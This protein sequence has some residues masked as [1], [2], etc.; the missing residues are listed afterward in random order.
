MVESGNAREQLL[1]VARKL[2]SETVTA[3]SQEPT[4]HDGWSVLAAGTEYQFGVDQVATIGRSGNY[5][6]DVPIAD[7]QAISRIH[8]VI[9]P[10]PESHQMVICDV[11]SAA[12]LTIVERS[13]QKF[14]Q[15]SVPGSR[16]PLLVG[17]HE[18][19]VLQLGPTEGCRQITINAK[20]CVICQV[21]ARAVEFDCGHFICCDSCTKRVHDGAFGPPLCPVCRVEVLTVTAGQHAVTMQKDTVRQL[22]RVRAALRR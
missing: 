8:A 12:G 10:M 21:K 6:N 7:G 22:T 16:R 4:E 5:D 17:N 2:R 3:D 14:H 1:E 18:T 13:G 15:Q 11:G 20:R 9:L 19:V